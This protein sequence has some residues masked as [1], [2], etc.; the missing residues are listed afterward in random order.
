MGTELRRGAMS[1]TARAGK[2]QTRYASVPISV[3]KGRGLYRRPR[4]MD[5]L[6]D[7]SSLVVQTS[8]GGGA[9]TS[10][11]PLPCIGPTT[12]AASM[13]STRRAARL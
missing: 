12:P 7:L 13:L 10:R 4:N 11:L 2:K 9:S 3:L 6:A 1:A 5:E 8:T